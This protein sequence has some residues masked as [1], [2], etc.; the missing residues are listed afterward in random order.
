MDLSFKWNRLF[1]VAYSV[2]FRN[3]P[4]K[5]SPMKVLEFF[6]IQSS[7]AKRSAHE[8]LWHRMVEDSRRIVDLSMGCARKVQ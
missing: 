6:G 5:K 8:L 3:A 7:G 4:V 1:G 2:Q